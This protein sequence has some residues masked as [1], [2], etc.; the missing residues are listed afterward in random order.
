MTIEPMAVKHSKVPISRGSAVPFDNGVGILIGLS[1]HP[2]VSASF[3]YCT[4][5]EQLHLLQ[6]ADLSFDCHVRH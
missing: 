2:N 5:L 6:C 3:R 1:L 4:I